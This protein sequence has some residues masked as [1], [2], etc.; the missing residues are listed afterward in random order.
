MHWIIAASL[1]CWASFLHQESLFIWLLCEHCIECCCDSW[2]LRICANHWSKL[3]KVT[4]MCFG[5]SSQISAHQLVIQH[6]SVSFF[7]F[8]QHHIATACEVCHRSPFSHLKSLK[9]THLWNRIS[10]YNL[11]YPASFNE[12]I[13]YFILW[14]T[15]VKLMPCAV[16]CSDGFNQCCWS[17]RFAIS[18]PKICHKRVKNVH[19]LTTPTPLLPREFWSFTDTTPSLEWLFQLFLAASISLGPLLLFLLF[20]CSE[21]G[22]TDVFNKLNSSFQD[23]SGK[24]DLAHSCVEA[25]VKLINPRSQVL[26][27]PLNCFRSYSCCLNGDPTFCL[28]V[29][30][31]LLFLSKPEQNSCDQKTP[32]PQQT[33]K[34]N[35]KTIAAN[36]F[37]WNKSH[38]PKIPSF[39]CLPVINFCCGY[40]VGWSDD[41]NDIWFNCS[42][43]FGAL[44]YR[45]NAHETFKEELFR[46]PDLFENIVILMIWKPHCC[47]L[48]TFWTKACVI[49]SLIEDLLFFFACNRFWVFSHLLQKGRRKAQ[50]SFQNKRYCLRHPKSFELFNFTGMLCCSWSGGAAKFQRKY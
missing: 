13:K 21:I 19:A 32:K 7:Q 6:L 46:L 31:F 30:V 9:S 16:P 45:T 49:I 3:R 11:Q 17:S 39:A 47:F 35:N 41:L 42:E 4:C 34:R 8:C 28:L 38:T 33:A 44:S 36:F 14:D 24:L 27:C 15:P 20:S 40:D 12:E 37:D 50:L 23:K 25:W 18:L 2:Y 10:W 22:L 1:S 26:D 48:S 43:M 5:Y 29:R